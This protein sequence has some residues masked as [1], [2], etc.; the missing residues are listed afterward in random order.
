[1]VVSLEQFF[2]LASHTICSL[3]HVLLFDAFV[4]ECNIFVA[5]CIYIFLI[6]DAVPS[7]NDVLHATYF[8]FQ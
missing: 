7:K 6:D 1:M 5:A 3:R 2:S 4:L 8:A